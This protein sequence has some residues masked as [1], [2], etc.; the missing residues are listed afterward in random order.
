[1]A[2]IV[3]HIPSW[4][5]GG[6]FHQAVKE[7]R[8]A[9]DNLSA[10]PYAFVLDQMSRNAHAPSFLSGLFEKNGIPEPG[11]EQETTFK[12]TA[13]TLFGGGADTVST[14]RILVKSGNN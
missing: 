2:K 13:T 3:K 1:M 10:K 4:F 7:F 5:P 9:A 8:V 6:G 11:S 14:R 12:W